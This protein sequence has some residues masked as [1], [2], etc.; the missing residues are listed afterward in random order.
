MSRDSNA[1]LSFL[2]MGRIQVI[3]FI[4]R[5]NKYKI[6][7]HYISRHNNH[8]KTQNMFVGMKLKGYEQVH[9]KGTINLCNQYR[10]RI[11]NPCNLFQ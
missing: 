1:L 8:H 7:L 6:V 10:Q 9:K 11:I 4:P 2:F 5:R 3:M